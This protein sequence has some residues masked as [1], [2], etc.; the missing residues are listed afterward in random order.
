MSAPAHPPSRPA[1][2][3]GHTDAAWLPEAWRTGEIAVVGLGRSGRAVTLLLASAG[4]RVYASDGGSGLHVAEGLGDVQSSGVSVEVGT[5]D[6]ERIA[7]SALVI[8]SPGIP[9]AAPPLARAHAAGVPVVSEI[10]VALH[11]LADVPY[12]AV[13]GTNGK[14]TTTALVGHLLRALGHAAVAAGNIGTPLSEV[15]LGAQRPAW[16]A[17]EL[18]SFQLHDTPSVAPTA[19]VL[20]NLAPD[21]L[22]RYETTAAY[23]AD[24]QLLFRNAGSASQWILNGDD[25]S[26]LDLAAGVA[27]AH[28]RFSLLDPA[29][30]A[31]L[32]AAA[33]LLVT[34]G[35]PL[36]ARS[37]LALIGAHNAA[38]ALAAT[39]AV[40]VAAPAHATPEAR[41][42]LAGALESFRPLPHRLE[43]VGEFEGVLW[44]NDSKAT[45]VSSAMVALEGMS[46]PTVVLLGGR[47]KGE[48][49]T[50]LAEPLRRVA[51]AVVAYGEAAPMIERDLAGTLPVERVSGPFS[52]VIE[53]ARSLARAGDAVLL[54][55]ACASYD[56]FTNY[57]ERGAEFRRLARGE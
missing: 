27:G 34:F 30:E 56:M 23:Y 40:M 7:R 46:R 6:L 54:S 2:A 41:P 32:D 26:V 43:R 53:R 36:L 48:P 38:N 4:A 51:R 3:G 18:S 1:T 47:D 9:P 15:A 44:I 24:K 8:A 31:Y 39:L 5:H 50:A 28:H 25:P 12:I 37:G 42:L 19:G 33:D 11:A 49:Y 20:T 57:E 10:E 29:A 52:N 35:V 14:T 22:D 17:L 16:I 21:H 13:T 45:N 55:P